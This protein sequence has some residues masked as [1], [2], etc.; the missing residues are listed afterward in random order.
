M[1]P[2]PRP[3]AFPMNEPKKASERM[4]HVIDPFI[5]M[6]DGERPMLNSSFSSYSLWTALTLYQVT[7]MQIMVTA[8]RSDQ[9]KLLQ[10]S[11]PIIDSFFGEPLMRLTAKLNKVNR[12]NWRL[13]AH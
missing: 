13:A 8:A 5:R 4:Y 2:P 9:L 10:S 11:I 1:K 3:K 12:R 7:M 6:Q